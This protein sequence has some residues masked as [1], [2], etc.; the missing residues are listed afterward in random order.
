MD[1]WKFI[2]EAEGTAIENP[3]GLNDLF[4]E[5]KKSHFRKSFYKYIGSFTEPPCE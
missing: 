3:V 1:K 4:C 2:E 5:H